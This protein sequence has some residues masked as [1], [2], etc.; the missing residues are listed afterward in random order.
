MKFK[1]GDLVTYNGPAF[2]GEGLVLK[3]NRIDKS[4][5]VHSSVLSFTSSYYY[6]IGSDS[7]LDI[8]SLVLIKPNKVDHLPEWL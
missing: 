3:I 1:V 2:L 7:C 8:K 4:G 5:L 6:K